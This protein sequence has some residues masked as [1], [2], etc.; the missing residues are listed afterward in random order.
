MKLDFTFCLY[1]RLPR[2]LSKVPSSRTR[3]QLALRKDNGSPT[4]P[5]LTRA[6]AHSMEGRAKQREENLYSQS[7]CWGVTMLVLIHTA[8]GFVSTTSSTSAQRQQ[9]G[10]SVPRGG[11]CA[12]DVVVMLL[13]LSRTMTPR[14]SDS[15]AASADLWKLVRPYI[16]A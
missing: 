8:V 11:I 2:K 3:H 16:N 1:Q 5:I 4:G 14:R 6:R 12:H 7:S 9:V 15:L 13:T 10:Q